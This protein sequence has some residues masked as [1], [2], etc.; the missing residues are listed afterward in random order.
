MWKLSSSRKPCINDLTNVTGKIGQ[1]KVLH[2]V[3]K[4]KEASSAHLIKGQHLCHHSQAMSHETK[5]LRGLLKMS[6]KEHQMIFT[7]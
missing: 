5:K 4:T 6:H 1:Q 7:V 2:G 3:L